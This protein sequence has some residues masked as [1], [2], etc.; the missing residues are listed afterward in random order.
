MDI[1]LKQAEELLSACAVGSQ[2]LQLEDLSSPKFEVALERL[3]A[4]MAKAKEEAKSLERATAEKAAQEQQMEQAVSGIFSSGSEDDD[5]GL[6]VR[7]LSIFV[8]A[9]PLC[10]VLLFSLDIYSAVPGGIP[11]ANFLGIFASIKGAIPFGD[12]VF[13]FLFSWLA[14][15]EGPS[16]LRYNLQQA[17]VLD[18]LSILPQLILGFTG[19]ALPDS[20]LLA[21]AVLLNG[22]IVYSAGV[23]LLGK[24]PDNIG[25]ISD[26]TKRGLGRP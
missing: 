21:G 24:T 7:L 2:E 22:C 10:D 5:R 15:Q 18:I 20:F 17:V 26:A 1:S 6:A 13:L 19:F 3:R 12:F 4:D 23:T 9:L 11:V 14:K 16:L 25:F 8:Y